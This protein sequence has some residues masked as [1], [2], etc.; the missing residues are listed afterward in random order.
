M[1]RQYRR[2]P[3]RCNAPVSRNLLER[4]IEFRGTD[5]GVLLERLARMRRPRAVCDLLGG[6]QAHRIQP[7]AARRRAP[8]RQVPRHGLRRR[9]AIQFILLHM[10]RKRALV[11]RAR[12][13]ALPKRPGFASRETAPRQP[14]CRELV[15]VSAPQSGAR[16]HPR[17][18]R[19]AC[20]P[21]PPRCRSRRAQSALCAR[22]RDA[23]QQPM[24]GLAYIG[25]L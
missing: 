19:E 10:D 7:R 25:R 2:H 4:G 16:P 20:T 15:V 17:F 18:G 22:A 11:H 12:H 8:D 23:A 3:R 5:A 24:A 9:A 13:Q 1:A 6:R 14:S 21:R